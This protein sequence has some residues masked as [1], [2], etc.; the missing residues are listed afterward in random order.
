MGE[1]DTHTVPYGLDSR[2][3]VTRDPDKA[4]HLLVVAKWRV[5]MNKDE[6]HKRQ[7]GYRFWLVL[8][9]MAASILGLEDME[10]GL[11]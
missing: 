9:G 11:C 1:Y 5:V 3:C 2:E 6:F 7:Q 8:G 10:F 4:A